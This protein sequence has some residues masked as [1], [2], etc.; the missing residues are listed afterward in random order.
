MIELDHIS[1]GYKGK[2]IVEDLSFKLSAGECVLLKGRNGSGKSTLLKTI[3]GLLPPVSGKINCSSI[4]LVPTRIPKV[5]GFTVEEFILTSLYK[6]AKWSGRISP[7]DIDS[8]RKAIARMG[9]SSLADRDISSLSDG[10]FQ[11]ACIA[12]ALTRGADTLLLDEPTA[13]LDVESRI[14]VFSLLS[15]LAR[16]GMCILFSSHDIH[17]AQEFSTRIIELD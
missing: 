9:I 10:E 14:A 16:S 4:V 6:E 3:A 12:T 7:E 15:E 17:E 8:A 5:K 11:K 1:I 13:F 2:T